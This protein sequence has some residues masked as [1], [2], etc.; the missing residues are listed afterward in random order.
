M[1]RGSMQDESREGCASPV[2]LRPDHVEVE[3]AEHGDRSLR[4]FPR[5]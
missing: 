3:M 4:H 2:S 5:A 1:T